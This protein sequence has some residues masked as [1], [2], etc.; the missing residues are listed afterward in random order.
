M[1]RPPF[2]VVAA[3]LLAGAPA[4]RAQ[5]APLAFSARDALAIVVHPSNPVDDLTLSELRRIFMFDTQTWTH[6]RKITVVVRERGQPERAEAIRLICGLGE[7][8]Y[9]KHVLLQTFRG[10]IGQGPREILSARAMLRFVFNAPGAI[11]YVPADEVDGTTKVLRIDG[12]LPNAP[13]Y[14]LRRRA[15]AP[16]RLPD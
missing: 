5:S 16:A 2:L 4:L 14:A 12:L 15:R 13:R 9:D 10:T 8:Q 1:K 11:G 7:E 6:G 3:V